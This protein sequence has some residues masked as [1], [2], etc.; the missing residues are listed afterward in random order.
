[1]ALNQDR[2]FIDAAGE[3][4][5][6]RQARRISFVGVLVAFVLGFGLVSL[7]IYGRI[8][9]MTPRSYRLHPRGYRTRS[10]Y[11]KHTVREK[12]KV[13]WRFGTTTEASTISSGQATG[14]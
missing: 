10:A 13:S 4:D 9:Q 2:E 5:A 11:A 7:L 6:R 12:D 1:M 8:L 14:R 3:A